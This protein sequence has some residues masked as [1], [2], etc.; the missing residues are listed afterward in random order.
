MAV[1][2]SQLRLEQALGLSFNRI[3]VNPD[4]IAEVSLT[5]ETVVVRGVM[6]LLVRVRISWIVSRE[7]PIFNFVQRKQFDV[8]HGNC[9]VHTAAG[10][11]G[12]LH[13]DGRRIV[14]LEDCREMS[15]G[16]ERHIDAIHLRKHVV[17]AGFIHA[18]AL[19]L[20]QVA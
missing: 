2:K 10:F 4:H 20:G 18:S 9:C 14:G 12:Q 8:R 16:I 15:L 13:L 5:D 17:G 7:R 19:D 3:V 6:H 11:I 1:C